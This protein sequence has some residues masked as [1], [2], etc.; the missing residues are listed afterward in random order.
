MSKASTIK[1]DE[2]TKTIVNEDGEAT[3]GDVFC[4][5]IDNF[6]KN[7]YFNTAAAPDTLDDVEITFQ[8]SVCGGPWTQIA[9][10]E[11]LA[12]GRKISTPLQAPENLCCQRDG[13]TG[14]LKFRRCDDSA[15]NNVCNN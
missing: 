2:C 9:N 7:G 11:T 1:L 8:Y 4:E 13:V 5:N 6:Y 14:K 12:D 10:N 15:Y 3:I